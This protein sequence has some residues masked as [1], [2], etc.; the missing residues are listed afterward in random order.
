MITAVIKTD[1]NAVRVHEEPNVTS[2]ELFAI[3][4]DSLVI[5]EEQLQNWSKI[6]Y[7]GYSG[8]IINQFLQYQEPEYV[9]ISKTKLQNFLKEL[10]EVL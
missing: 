3:P 9:E 4:R 7:N 10:Y 1:S 6:S 2:A 8:Y 5:I